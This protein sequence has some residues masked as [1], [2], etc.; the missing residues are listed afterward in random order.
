MNRGRVGAVDI[1]GERISFAR[2]SQLMRRYIGN[3]GTF[4]RRKPLGAFGSAIAFILIVVAIF[5]PQIATDNPRETSADRTFAKPGAASLLGGDQLGRD[6]FSRLVY[7]SRISLQVGLLS[8]LFGITTGC[9]IGIASAYFGGRVDLIVQRL[10]D[11]VQAFPPLILALAIMAALGASVTNVIIALTIVFIPGA[12]RTIRSQALSIKEID[13]VLAARAIGAGDW[14]IILRHM[15]PNCFATFI[16]LA[17]LSLGVAI[18]AEASLSFLGVGTPPDVPS[19]GGMLTGAAQNYVEV[20]PWLGV[21]PGLA[22]A[23]VVF[24]WNLL[25]DSLRDVLDPRLRGMG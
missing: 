6:V 8:V 5:A 15:V 25:G 22:I 18:I 21:F 7:G 9:F 12:A 17:T 10:V 13:Y 11:S 14:R 20:A 4:F 19:W 1:P 24:A 2:T 3:V 16:V 23:V